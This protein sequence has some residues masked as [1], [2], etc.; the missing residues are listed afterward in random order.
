MPAATL[1]PPPP[2]HARTP[3]PTPP[4]H[5]LGAPG[6]RLRPAR[7]RSAGAAIAPF[8]RTPPC[9][10]RLLGLQLTLVMETGAPLA[11][12]TPAPTSSPGQKRCCRSAWPR[13]W[14]ILKPRRVDPGVHQLC[15]KRSPLSL[16]QPC[17]KRFPLPLTH[18]CHKR[19]PLP[20]ITP[21]TS[22][23]LFRSSPLP[24]AL[25]L[26]DPWGAVDA[27]PAFGSGTPAQRLELWRVEEQTAVLQHAAWRRPVDTTLLP[28]RRMHARHAQQV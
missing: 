13:G 8:A 26:R 1:P 22:A 20:F 12:G 28:Y 11:P 24:Q 25:S 17:H 21:A 16:T 19:F 27:G 9:S 5:W 18:P 14:G 23:F 15:C 4:P 2:L 6:P 7:A 3:P 10:T